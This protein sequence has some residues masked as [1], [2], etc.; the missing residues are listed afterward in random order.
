MPDTFSQSER[1]ADRALSVGGETH[2]AEYE[3]S[4]GRRKTSALDWI[5]LPLISAATIAIFCGGIRLISY[6]EFAHLK[7]LPGRCIVQSGSVLH[8]VPNSVCTERNYYSQLVEYRF[9]SCG[10]RTPFDCRQKP[11]GVYRIVLIG[12]SNPMGYEVPAESTLSERLSAELS[13]RTGRRVEVYNASL[14]GSSGAPSNLANRMSRTMAL[15]PDLIL[16]VM[17]AWDI[18][19]DKSEDQIRDEALQGSPRILRALR[20]LFTETRAG[21]WMREILY[22]SQS[23]YTAA[24]LKRIQNEAQTH[25]TPN[26][27]EHERMRLVSLDVRTIVDRAKADGVPVVVAFLPDR[28]VADA[29]SMS[30]RPA[31]IEPDRLN[32]ELHTVLAGKGA[33]FA[34]V[35]PDLRKA[36]N[37][38]GLYDPFGAH[39]NAEGHA[40]LTQILENFLTSGVVPA[41]SVNEQA[42]SERIQQ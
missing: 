10:D 16:W 15:Q 30:P 26:D 18:N 6:L 7:W 13:R 3:E 2:A 14:N 40:F 5:V 27:E 1:D 33:I 4:G 39:L 8:G 24:Y 42:Q 20:L 29:F 23:L 41:L 19:P 28:A 34:D 9:N 37:L 35:V 21:Y 11:E 25:A 22:R 31:G 36:L 12:S 32:N 38:D 17:N